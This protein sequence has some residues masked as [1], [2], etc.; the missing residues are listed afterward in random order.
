M[1]KKK[2][3]KNGYFASYEGEEFHVL[4]VIRYEPDSE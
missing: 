3:K 1:A 4:P 2:A